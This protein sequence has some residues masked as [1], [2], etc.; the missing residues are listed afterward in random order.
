[1]ITKSDRKCVHLNSECNSRRIQAACLR[2]SRKEEYRHTR[3]PFDATDDEARPILDRPRAGV[4]SQDS[5]LQ[6]SATTS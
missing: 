6:D 3:H 2:A 5:R 4:R 1:M